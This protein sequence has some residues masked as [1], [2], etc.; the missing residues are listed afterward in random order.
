MPGDR[1]ST[2]RLYN[3]IKL[4]KRRVNRAD[5]RTDVGPVELSSSLDSVGQY[6]GNVLHAGT[7]SF[8]NISESHLVYL[9][10]TQQ[11]RQASG[12]VINS[13][14]AEMLGIALSA[15]PHTDGVL[16]R[17]IYK[18]D[19]SYVSG[20]TGT[21]FTIGTQVYMHPTTSGSFTTLQPTGSNEAVRVIGHSI[22]TEV[23]YFNPSQDYIEL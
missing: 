2:K 5:V 18:L 3:E 23:I 6:N 1:Q 10:P 7:G 12:G 8:G 13:G 20:S 15:T 16:V 4:L 9:D 21:F 14:S 19:P 11:W 22:D 17:G